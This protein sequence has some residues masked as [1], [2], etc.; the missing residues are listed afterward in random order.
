MY[1]KKLL[2][3]IAIAAAIASPALAKQP[4]QIDTNRVVVAPSINVTTN[5]A[6]Q[7]ISPVPFSDMNAQEI[8]FNYTVQDVPALISEMPS[9]VFYSQN[10]NNTGYSNLTLRGFDQRRIAV[11]INGIPQNDP[12]DHNVYWVDFPDITSSLDNIQVQRGA[13]MANY[14]SAAI[15]GSVNLTTSNFVNKRGFTAMTGV[16]VQEFGYSDLMQATT[17]KF[18]LEASSGL[19]NDHAFYG[20][21][22][23]ITTNGYRD[24]SGSTL[25]SFFLSAV[26]FDKNFSTQINVFGGPIT[27]ELCYTGLPKS[28]IGSTELRRKNLS[29]FAYDSTGKNVV[30]PSERR[31]Q[32][33]EGFYQP[34]YEI[35]NNWQ[36][37]DNLELKSALFYYSGEGYYDNDIS[38]LS[39]KFLFTKEFG[40]DSP[41][42]P[43]NGI[44]RATVENSH[45]GWIPRLIWKNLAGET[46][47][48]A[49]IRSHRSKHYGQLTYSENYPAGYD[50][51]FKIYYYEG[52]KDVLSGFLRHRAEF[53]KLAL[54]AEAQLVNNTYLIQNEKHGTQYTKY[55]VGIGDSVGNGGKIFSYDYFFFNP[56]LGATYK[57]DDK[58]TVYSQIAYT[59]REPRLRQLYAA[60]DAIFGMK[61]TCTAMPSFEYKNG[62]KGIYDFSK[63]LLKPEK[64]LNFE[65][66]ANY[67]DS[68]F[69]FGVN[70]YY[71]DYRDE[72]VKS[73][74]VDYYGNPI[75]GNAPKSLH[76]GVELQGSAN[77]YTKGTTSVFFA[78]NAT[79]S[80]NRIVDYKYQLGD[81]V[82]VSLDD[83]PV[84]G[85]PDFMANLRL[86]ANFDQLRVSL[87]GKYTGESRT[88]NFGDML[89]NNQTLKSFLIANDN[90]YAD[91]KL[92]AAFVMNADVSYTLT[93]AFTF[94]RIRFFAQ[95]NNIFNKLYAAGGEGKEF[96]VAAERNYF[97][98]IEVGF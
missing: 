74:M 62:V 60:E 78:A 34:H 50:P 72:L 76:A 10:G 75:E 85:F 44:Y 96:F 69:Q 43:V 79:I 27:D 26:R 95:A 25:Y 58:T 84:A 55:A 24:R 18:S 53:G 83:N 77:I 19:I 82:V 32:E 54:S 22:S 89:T 66:G 39:A 80:H 73:G 88:D 29:Y 81:G 35:L 52:G 59:S 42:G 90:Y 86:T 36:I 20:R 8:K 94:E 46:V 68:R 56:R 28:Y 11:M 4:T 2:S 47:I 7:G 45:G 23:K 87:F 48:G 63:P 12:E 6:T 16:G 33:K 71:M 31:P 67:T 92:D 51:D 41:Q 65:L 9:V 3:R 91:N 40:W 1:Y 64:M 5:R 70:A 49:E 14:G 21:L 15:G 30:W 57:L 97:F 17:G 93:N 98:G 38:W 61:D 13:G 37:S